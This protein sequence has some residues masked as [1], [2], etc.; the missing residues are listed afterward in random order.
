MSDLL[1]LAA[2]KRASSGKCNNRRSRK[3][4][5]V[6]GVFYTADG[7][8]ISVQVPVR[9]LEKVYAKVRRTTVFNL[10]IDDNG[11]KT[12]YPALVWQVQR[13]PIKSTFTHI[14]FFGVDLEKPIKI[15]VPVEFTGVAKGTKVGGVM[16][17]YRDQVR[18]IAKPLDMPSKI[19]IDVTPLELGTTLSVADLP[20]AEGVKAAYDTNYAIVSVLLPGKAE[21]EATAE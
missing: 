14:D 21:E 6:P 9:D 11:S 20:L 10:E 7:K 8:N 5:L 15:I 12:A 1:V 16:E 17:T 4:D 2:Q 19:V 3:Q 13:D 18:L